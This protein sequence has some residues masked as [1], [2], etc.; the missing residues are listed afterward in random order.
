[1]CASSFLWFRHPPVLLPGN[2]RKIHRAQ[3]TRGFIRKERRPE[4]KTEKANKEEEKSDSEGTN[5]SPWGVKRRDQTQQRDRANSRKKSKIWRE[6]GSWM[7]LLRSQPSNW[8]LAQNVC[9]LRNE[10]KLSGP[11]L[12]EVLLQFQELFSRRTPLVLVW[13][14]LN[15]TTDGKHAGQEH[16]PPGWL[17][18][19]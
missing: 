8:P 17:P 14:V 2:G 1:M 15:A 11:S 7:L 13:K 9:W 5:T 16:P 4:R 3:E 18:R 19:Q 12:A 10:Y 6:D